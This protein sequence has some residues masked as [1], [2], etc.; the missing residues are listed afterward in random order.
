MRT[1]VPA[2][3]FATQT[4]PGVVAMLAGPSS[5]P[6]ATVA[7][8]TR[9]SRS[10]R[11]TVPSSGLATQTASSPTA[12]AATPRLIST[13]WVAVEV[14]ASIGVTVPVD[15][16]LAHTT[17]S[18]HASLPGWLS[19][20]TFFVRRLLTGS[21]R[22]TAYS[23]G[24]ATQIAP[25][26]AQSPS[27]WLPTGIRRAIWFVRGEMTDTLP[28]RLSATHTPC[29]STAIADGAFPTGMVWRMVRVSGSTR[30]TRLR[31]RSVT[32]TA[33]APDAMP[34]GAPSSAT[35]PVRAPSFGS[36]AATASP[37]MGSALGVSPDPASSATVPAAAAA[38]A[39]TPATTRRRRPRAGARPASAARAAATS[40]APLA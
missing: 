37:S 27:T 22:T 7:V 36:I 31:S 17:P 9:R 23:S 16:L 32:Q 34:S 40:S 39:T 1:S 38:S 21:R 8:T 20:V 6:T 35:L 29:G 25:P 15:G 13:G 11:D 2:N 3:S 12:R 28:S 18:P 24:A 10:I 14:A 26:S 30:E 33:P 19:S 4:A 5:R